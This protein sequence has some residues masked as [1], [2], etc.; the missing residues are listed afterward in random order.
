MIGCPGRPAEQ[1]RDLAAF[2]ESDPTWE[3]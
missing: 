2:F 3:R 1:V